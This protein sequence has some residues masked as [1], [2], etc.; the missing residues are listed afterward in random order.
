MEGRFHVGTGVHARAGN[1]TG[2]DDRPSP[3]FQIRKAPAQVGLPGP[4]RRAIIEVS[5]AFGLLNEASLGAPGIQVRNR[6]KRQAGT[7]ISGEFRAVAYGFLSQP[8]GC[9]SPPSAG[10]FS[11]VFPARVI[12]AGCLCHLPAS[13]EPVRAVCDVSR[14]GDPGAMGIGAALA[15]KPAGNRSSSLQSR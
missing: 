10:A 6:V 1:G 7:G 11:G 13:L 14:R 4:E 15:T 12:L 2:E 8:G 9:V 5:R 3:G